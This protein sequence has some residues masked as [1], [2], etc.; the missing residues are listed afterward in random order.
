MKK[1]NIHV[2]GLFMVLVAFWGTSCGD[3]EL[4][5]SNGLGSSLK[6]S[7]NFKL[8]TFTLEKGVW[9]VP[10]TTGQIKIYLQ[11]HTDNS[12]RE[13]DVDVQNN[14]SDFSFCIYI[15]KDERI[16][17]SDYDLTAFFMNGIRLGTKL[18]VTFRDEMLHGV[19]A[20]V[21]EYSLKGEGTS[22]DPYLI[23][24]KE[25]FDTF[26]YDLSRDSIEHAAGRYFRQTTDF[27]VP[28]RSDVY[29]GRYYA[30]YLF[31]G[32]YDGSGHCVMLP[33][34]GS[35]EDDDNSIGLFKVLC[36]GAEIKNLVVKPRMQGIKSKGGALAG[37]SQDSVSIT[38]VTVDGSITGCGDCIGGFIGYATGSLIIKDCRL[39]A[40]INGKNKIGGLVGCMENGLLTVNGFSNLREDY[41]PYLF[42][43]NAQEWSAGGI[44]GAIV[45][46]G[47]QL[48]DITFQHSISEE[49]INLKVIYAGSGQAGG[50][51]GDV[52]ISRPS[53]LRGVK[54]LAPVRSEQNEVG[55]LMGK[56][57][58]SADLDV[59]VCTV[60]SLVKGK[61]SIGG[62]FGTLH[63][64]NHLVLD[65]RDKANRV[66]QVDNG[67]IAIEGIKYVGGMFGYLEGD[68]Q[69]KSV[70]LINADVTA[71]EHF[72]GG[73]AGK[74]YKNT[75]E[76]AAFSLDANM[77]VQ[78][79]DAIGGLV[80]FAEWSTIKGYLSDDISFSSLPAADGFRSNFA[81]TVSSGR[82]GN[83]GEGGD[84]TSMGGIVGYALDTYLEGLCA[85]GKVFGREKV[86]GIV[87]HLRNKTRGHVRNCVGNTAAVKNSQ[88]VHT[89][90]I[91]GR[92]S[93]AAGSY[94]HLVNY[95]NVEGGN[96][97]GGIVGY[98]EFESSPSDFKLDYAVNIGN[99]SGGQVVGGCVGFLVHD[100][101]I[102]HTISNSANY[103]KIVNSGDNG[104]IGGIIGQGDASRM[105]VM[106]CA[107]HGEIAGGNGAS[108]VGGIAGRLGKDPGG[109]GFTIGENM[110]MGYCC[111]RG[112][113]SS[114]NND[115]H[116]GG[117]LGYQEEGN[118][119]DDQHW[120][121]HDC[122]NTG[123]V[124]SDQHDDNGGI[125]GCVD[126]YAEVVR[127][128]NI[129][130]VL[131]GNG[132][133]GTH[134][135]SIW[136]HHNLYYLKESGDGWCADSFTENK[137]KEKNTFS[138]F[139]FDNDWAID[140]ND[141]MNDGF[142][143]LRKCPFQ[144][145]YK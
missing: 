38:N 45:N 113:I 15:P 76:G 98:I 3:D 22:D 41:S 135:G 13:Y 10:D 119:Y 30:G 58:L 117:L 132:V 64:N 2:I 131:H 138:G 78:G 142:P 95:G 47:C 140:D 34:I 12:T 128:I 87:G 33:Y 141:T 71:G 105:A 11:S 26:G 101:S 93:V 28:P 37:V 74:Q 25:D 81:G 40:E 48:N 97:T 32:S 90:G 83:D 44:A 88:G 86:G 100:K 85:T 4:Y 129:G 39:F 89:G 126:H 62:F 27:E 84:G 109:A 120:M 36:K 70:S 123:T 17:D 69:A 35:Q 50:I 124:T 136:H 92:L 67:Y 103:G 8:S 6:E 63:S 54:I 14:G 18:K 46:G 125:I 116:V 99:I 107:N 102:Q 106:Y 49:D 77:R 115:S 96:L 79:A 110:E 31:A 104:N 61:E 137:K 134:H 60:G 66:V 114:G 20:S 43:V 145:I 143:Y 127:C 94:D 21:V 57:D 16:P 52:K 65:G 73:V 7:D 53:S 9:D 108:K 19:L 72:G 55:G 130:D 29:E 1:T 59:Q 51:A 139:N 5:R 23:G 91:I 133:V 118:D 144:S 75:L 111:N 112:A 42:T 24:S 122:Y 121:T 56:V 68:I 82:K 80:G